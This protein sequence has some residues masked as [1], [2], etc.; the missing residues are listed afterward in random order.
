MRKKLII[1]I[2]V[3][4]AWAVCGTATAIMYYG[5]YKSTAA[6]I[7]AAGGDKFVE[8]VKQHGDTIV[9][10]L[11][12]VVAVR[13]ELQSAVER[14][15]ELEQ[16]IERATGYAKL[17]DAELVDFGNTMASSGN[18][19]QDAINLQQR[20][21]EFARRIQKNNSAIKVELGVRP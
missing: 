16:R 12:D 14:T 20:T 18:T 13:T 2:A 1:V 7:D 3:L 19:L 9:G 5:E 6:I 10:V 21:I 11:D 17:T 15:A 8:L 4:F